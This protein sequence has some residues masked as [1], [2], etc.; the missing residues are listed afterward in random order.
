MPISKLHP[1]SFIAALTLMFLHL[2]GHAAD[3]SGQLS[4]T[5]YKG[6]I[7]GWRVEMVRTLTQTDENHYTLRSEA[8][9]LFA[10]IKERSDFAV[11]D[12]QL[13]PMNYVYERRVFGRQTA[14]KIIFDWNTKKAVYSRSDRP[15]NTEHNLSKGLLDPALY[16]L[17]LQA[18]LAQKKTA[19]YYNFIK[20]KRLESYEFALLSTE[21]FALQKKTYDALV[22]ERK[23]KEKDKITKV[24][25]LPQL[26][27][28]VGKIQH[29]DDGDTYE[30]KLV[31]YTSDSERLQ[32]FYKA[33]G[34][35]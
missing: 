3:P 26:D 15:K 29:T 16:Q 17:A 13:L 34:K 23:D 25:I 14:E 1:W 2:S 10:S 31:S 21:Q 33:I 19:F 6:S 28:Q 7:S 27:Y 32:Q 11:V 35:K 24:W 30:V 5:V 12:G 20:R 4:R 18:D 22:M 8:E 9:N